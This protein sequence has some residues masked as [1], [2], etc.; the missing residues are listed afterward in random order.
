MQLPSSSARLDCLVFGHSAAGSREAVLIELKQW[1]EAAPSEWDEC[2]ESIVGGGMRKVLH[3]SV[4]ALRYS[5]YLQD[6]STAFDREKVGITLT[7]CAWLHN[8]HPGAAGVLRSTE[9]A[10]ILKQAPL[11]VASDAVE[12]A[13]TL[14]LRSR[15][16]AVSSGDGGSC[17]D[18]AQHDE[19]DGSV[20]MRRALH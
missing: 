11:F 13:G 19:Y 20:T 12:H 7:P 2:V 17:F 6:T 5:Q 16:C 10:G 15:P 9:F 3:P 18:G 1:T 4:Q 8:M 14:G